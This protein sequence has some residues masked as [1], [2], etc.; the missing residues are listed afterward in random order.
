M[1]GFLKLAGERIHGFERLLEAVS[2][3]CLKR[4]CPV[5]SQLTE[6]QRRAP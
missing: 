2:N 6:P 3:Q 1:L 5:A 4:A